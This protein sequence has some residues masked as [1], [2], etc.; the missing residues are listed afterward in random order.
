MQYLT[1]K[2]ILGTKNNCPIDSPTMYKALDQYGKVFATH[3]A[4]GQNIDFE[5]EA[6][7]CS[8]AFGRA[9]WSNSANATKTICMGLHELWDGTNRKH[10]FCDGGKIY[11]FDSSRDQDDVSGGTTFALHAIDLYSIIQYGTYM[12]FADHAEHEPYKIDHDDA[13]VSALIASGTHYKFR[14]LLTFANR[15]I[16]LYSDQTNPDLDIRYTDAL[17]ETTFPAANQLF[18]PGNSITGGIVHGHN[19][20][21][22]FSETDI[23]RMDYYSAATP[24]F[25][26]VPVTDNWGAVNHHCLVSDDIHMYFYDRNKGFARFDGSREPVVISGDYEGMINRIPSSYANLITGKLLPFTN[27]IV[28]NIPVDNDTAPSKLIYFNTKTGQ[29]RHENKVVRC[30]DIWRTFTNITGNDLIVLTDDIWPSSDTWAYYTS[31]SSKLVFANTDGHLYTQSSEGD[32]DTDWDAYRIEPILPFPG[33]DKIRILEVWA[34]IAEK[35]THSLDFSWRGG[36]TV[37][38]VEQAA[39]ASIGSISMNSPD[40]AVTY[41]DRTERKHQI[42]WGT[43]LKNEPYS[44]NELRI[45]YEIAGKY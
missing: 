38:E 24:V 5:R 33:E 3:D 29:W 31:E 8:K 18:K 13:N 26:L 30:I 34:S 14:Y 17:A 35:Q 11:K 12:I 19:T 39:W 2:P 42:K 37:G 36:D 28:W 27:E 32:N 6:D 25:K 15:I 20:G 16:G 4:G 21:Y 43:N 9:Q 10:F 40:D 41:T 22:I 45:G 7:S 44:V 23:V 1:I